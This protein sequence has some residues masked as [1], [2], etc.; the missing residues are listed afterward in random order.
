M[1]LAQRLGATEV[2]LHPLPGTAAVFATLASYSD[3][4]FDREFLLDRIDSDETNWRT[5]R[6][7]IEVATDGSVRRYENAVLHPVQNDLELAESALRRVSES[8]P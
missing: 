8:S 5:I 3:A 1:Q 7:A 4:E 6:Y 2:K